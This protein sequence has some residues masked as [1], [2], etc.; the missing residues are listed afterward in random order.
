MW[1]PFRLRRP[2]DLWSRLPWPA[3]LARLAM[4]GFFVALPALILVRRAVDAADARRALLVAEGAVV[5][6]AAAVLVAALRWARRHDLSLAES[7]HVVL[8]TTAATPT[9]RAPHVAR[10]LAPAARGV[11]P[12]AADAPADHLR[13]IGELAAT[14][15]HDAAREATRAARAV[16][17]GITRLDDEV[18]TLSRDA[19]PAELDRLAAQLGALGAAAGHESRERRELRELVRHQ[20]ELVR[21]MRG[22][23]EVASG[24]RVYLV[25]LLRGLWS[26][27]C[28][29]QD[30]VAAAAPVEPHAARL[31]A[32]CREVAAALPDRATGVAFPEGAP[33]PVASTPGGSRTNM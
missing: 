31:R 10:L 3:R 7:V 8:G 22:R 20:L 12:P 33:S 29:L 14:L 19:T 32:L 11:R 4:S 16:L 24:E 2:G 25:D 23:L 21:R 6:G 1:W 28:A 13:A 30:A 18:A 9:W 5:I 26:Q 17:A 15:R 27:L